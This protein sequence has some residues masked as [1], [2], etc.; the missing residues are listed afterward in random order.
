MIIN[1]VDPHIEEEI[2]AQAERNHI[3]KVIV[4]GSRARGDFRRTSDIDIAVYGGNISGF[5][6][7]IEEEV[8]TLLK[9]DVVDL[10]K[11][12]EQELLRSIVEEGKLLYEK[13]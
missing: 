3:K 13:V 7:D 1:G 6:V 5:M 8:R 11:P 12:M 2:I 9:F 4:F 10:D